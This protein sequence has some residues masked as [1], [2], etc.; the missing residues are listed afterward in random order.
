MDSYQFCGWAR[1]QAEEK[2]PEPSERAVKGMWVNHAL[3]NLIL[4]GFVK[5]PSNF[6][7]GG[8]S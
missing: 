3:G 4:K 8:K 5:G 6:T 7:P 2:L 1:K